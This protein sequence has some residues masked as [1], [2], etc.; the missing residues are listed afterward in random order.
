M[1]KWIGL[2]I[3][4]GFSLIRALFRKKTCAPLTWG[5]R[6][7]FSW[8]KTGDLFV[9]CQFSWKT[10]DLFYF[11]L[12]LCSSLS[13][14]FISIVHSGVAHYF[15]PAQNLPLLL[16]GALFVGSLFGRTCMP[17]STAALDSDATL[18]LI[19]LHTDCVLEDDVRE[20]LNSSNN[21]CASKPSGMTGHAWGSKTD[22]NCRQCRP[23]AAENTRSTRLGRGI[24]RL[25]SWSLPQ[26][27]DSNSKCNVNVKFKVTLHEQVRYRGTLQYYQNSS[28]HAVVWF[29]AM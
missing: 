19:V 4:A 18:W 5:G 15:R 11:L 25:R 21:R 1:R 2:W 28:H 24:V 9:S 17:K 26:R 8:K 13:L 10:V 29:Q 14:L 20:I 12:F 3:R 27:E 6:P 23:T 7:Y 22:K 16:W